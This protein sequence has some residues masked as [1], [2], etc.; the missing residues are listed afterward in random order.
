M[1]CLNGA[2]PQKEPAGGGEAMK[3]RIRTAWAGLVCTLSAVAAANAFADFQSPDDR[4][5]FLINQLLGA[6]LT[7]EHIDDRQSMR[8]ASIS[9]SV[10]SDMETGKSEG[11][12][13]VLRK[14]AGILDLST[15]ELF[16][17]ME[18]DVAGAEI[19]C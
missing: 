10:L 14:I 11:R 5:R 16:R 7:R 12:P 8:A 4:A 13:G 6:R 19:G 18:S 2:Q 15:D 3:R 17:P 9:P 1:A